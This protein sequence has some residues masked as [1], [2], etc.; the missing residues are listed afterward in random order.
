[1]CA[2]AL[3]LKI[4]VIYIAANVQ[5]NEQLGRIIDSHTAR[6]PEYPH[7]TFS[8]TWSLSLYDG[9]SPSQLCSEGPAARNPQSFSICFE[10]SS[11]S[12]GLLRMSISIEQNH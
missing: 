2:G 11:T 1:M 8:F 9:T 6:D 5:W 4:Y 10:E 3:T 12:L 7:L